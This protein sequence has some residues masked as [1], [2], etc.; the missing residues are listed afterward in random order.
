MINGTY[1]HLT[2]ETGEIITLSAIREKINIIITE[3]IIC[4]IRNQFFLIY[5]KLSNLYRPTG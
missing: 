2:R 5:S 1:T 4:S 3:D